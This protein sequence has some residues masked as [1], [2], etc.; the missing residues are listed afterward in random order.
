MCQRARFMAGGQVCMRANF[1]PQIEQATFRMAGLNFEDKIASTPTPLGSY[2]RTSIG[3]QPDGTR[4]RLR[5]LQV[6]PIPLHVAP[7]QIQDFGFSA[8]LEQDKLQC[9]DAGRVYRLKRSQRL[10]KAS[11]FLVR[12]EALV[13]SWSVSPNIATWVLIW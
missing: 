5:I 3:T 4:P 10:A 7:P 12:Q 11:Q 13:L 9:G 2:Q 8:T 6:Q 1:P